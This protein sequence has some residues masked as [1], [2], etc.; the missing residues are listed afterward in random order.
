MLIAIPIVV[1]VIIIIIAILAN[2]RYFRRMRKEAAELCGLKHKPGT[3]Q[4]R[5]CILEAKKERKLAKAS[6][7]RRR[8]RY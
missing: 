4:Y 6:M 2:R 8:H 5:I 1:F 3:K 7:V